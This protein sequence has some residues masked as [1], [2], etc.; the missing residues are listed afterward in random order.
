MEEKEKIS[1]KIEHLT[2]KYGKTTAVEDLNLFIEGGDIFGFIG[3]N[4][5]GKTT[6]IKCISGLLNYQSGTIEINNRNAENYSDISKKRIGYVPDTPFLYDKLTGRE[7]L[8]FV[9]RIY[10]MKE[11][12][13]EKKIE[14][15]SRE[16]EFADYMD[17][18]TE[19]YS[20]G[21]K[22]RIVIA[23]AFIHNPNILLVDE[24]M[25][26]LDPKSSRIVKDLFKRVAQEDRI[27]FVSTHTLSLAEEIC[28]KIGIMDRGKL[29]YF[30]E[31][32]DLKNKIKKNNLEDIFLEITKNNE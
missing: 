31:I 26:G 8:Y 29:V 6:T 10:G 28:N 9:G 4:G 18:R 19:E 13:I 23:S 27:L 15:Y 32:K 20:H 22:Q 5:A 25:V 1:L 2:K 12:D 16:M 30:G 7:F 3:P 17:A 21:M 14:F 24:P 11:A